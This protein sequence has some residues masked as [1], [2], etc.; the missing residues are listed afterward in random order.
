MSAAPR[1]CHWRERAY[2]LVEVVISTLII[3]VMFAAAMQSVATARLGMQL[4]TDQARAV[5][6]AEDLLAEILQ[7][8]YYDSAYDPNSFGLGADE[9]IGNRSLFEDVDD[10]DQWSAAPPQRKDG[11]EIPG[12]ESWTRRVDVGWVDVHTLL[13]APYGGTP[14]TAPGRSSWN[15]GIKLVRV[16]VLRADAEIAELTAL[17]VVQWPAQTEQAELRAEWDADPND[18]ADG[19]G[20]GELDPNVIRFDPNVFRVDPNDIVDWKKLTDSVVP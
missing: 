7:Q 17:R 3:G 12:F 4:N 2:S 15:E 18:G 8:A 5:L 10:Y 14:R 20:L 19:V 6:L 1:P 11:T 9:D 13:P 16:R